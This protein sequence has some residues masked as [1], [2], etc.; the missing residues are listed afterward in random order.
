MIN[1]KII[2]IT[3]I[4]IFNAN[5]T[6]SYARE[7]IKIVGSS[8]VYPFAKAVS[9]RFNQITNLNLP[10]IE[11]TGSGS[12]FKLFCAGV[13]EGHPDINN[14]SRAMQQSEKDLCAKNGVKEV[15]E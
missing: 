10:E 6:S 4:V 11:A 14:A 15:S 12:G 13:G 1:K 2:L 9:R 5:I 7:T 3:A 8:T